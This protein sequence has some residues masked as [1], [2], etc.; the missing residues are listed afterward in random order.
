MERDLT[1][2]ERAYFEMLL[3][4]A[5]PY[6]ENDPILRQLDGEDQDNDRMWA[7]IAKGFLE[8]RLR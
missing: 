6:D 8:G 2:E 1:P 5:E 4:K 7:T 3:A